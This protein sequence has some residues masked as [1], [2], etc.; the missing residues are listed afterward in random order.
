MKTMR[1]VAMGKKTRAGLSESTPLVSPKERSEE[2][3]RFACAVEKMKSSGIRDLRLAD[4]L[5]VQAAGA[6]LRYWTQK[7]IT[8]CQRL[9]LAASALTEMRP[10]NATEAMLATQM[11]A[12]HDA[13]LMFLMRA[14]LENQ[15]IDGCDA[16]VL[17]ATR[18]MRLFTE[19]LQAMQKLKGTAAQQKVTVEHVHVHGGGQ[20]IVGAVA[21]R[22]P[23]EG[24]GGENRNRG[25]TP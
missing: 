13:A 20:A 12:A 19:Q 23:G 11:I 18:L 8:P 1:I 21:A 22:I 14:T 24:V 7:D 5:L 6:N 16:N 17:R 9:D 10:S 15:T 3:E 4:R 2:H 25:N